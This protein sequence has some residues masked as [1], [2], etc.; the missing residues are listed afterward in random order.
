[1]NSTPSPNTTEN[2]TPSPKATE[3]DDVLLARADQ[4][5]AHAHEQIARA[6]E[7]IARVNDQLSKLEHD[8][9]RHPSVLSRRG[10]RGLIGLLLAACIFVAAFVSQASHSDA[11]K[12]IVAGWAP[13]RFLAS[14][15]PM[16][17]SAPP[18]Q[19]SPS[20][21]Q[22]AAAEPLASQP[23]LP[24]QTASQDVAPAAAP[25]PLE[26]TELL[27]TMTRDLANVQQGIDQ[28]KTSQEEMARENAKTAEQLKASQEQMTRVIAN[29]S[30]QNLRPRTSAPPP[31]AIVTPARKPVPTLP[32]TQARAQV[33]APVQLRP[34][35]R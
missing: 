28:L 9:A 21:V 17:K 3:P 1:M 19:S 11:A 32:S 22:V 31:S 4:R 33:R 26:V 20:T 14:S 18:A 10:L 23:T 25:I 5:L 7:Q 2:S 35:Q 24:A 34:E 27:Q 6:E 30:E 29:I 16:E 15:P 13:Q 12:L 8:G